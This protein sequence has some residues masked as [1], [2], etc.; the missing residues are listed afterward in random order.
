M[1]EQCAFPCSETHSTAG[2][3][4]LASSIAEYRGEP[5]LDSQRRAGFIDLARCHSEEV[6]SYSICH[7]K[8][9]ETGQEID[10]PLS[11]K[12][13]GQVPPRLVKVLSN[14]ERLRKNTNDAQN[15]T[16]RHI[17]TSNHRVRYF[18]ME[19]GHTNKLYSAGQYVSDPP[20]ILE[21]YPRGERPK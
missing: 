12:N 3:C 14:W 5:T 15:T 19:G 18:R 9:S 7:Q 2:R 8:K 11:T 20:S 10:L 6:D 21:I 4:E 1:S 16:H 17:C 13:L